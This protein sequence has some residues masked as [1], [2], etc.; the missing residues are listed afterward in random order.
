MSNSADDLDK[1]V[2][3]IWALPQ[4]FRLWFEAPV[5]YHR[6]LGYLGYGSCVDYF[7]SGNITPS[8]S[9]YWLERLKALQIYLTVSSGHEGVLPV[10]Y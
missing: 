10:S 8:G 7:E 5:K 3:F 2:E 1:L 9:D 4:P 6:F